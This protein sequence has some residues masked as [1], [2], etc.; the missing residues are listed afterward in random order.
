MSAKILVADDSVTIQTAVQLTL[1]RENVELI[2]A[3]SGEEAVR[4]AKEVTPDLMLIDTGLPDVSGYEVCR[5]LKADPAIR[6]VPIIMLTGAS[7]AGTASQ[8][9]AVAASDFIVKPFESQTLITK[10]RQHLDARPMSRSA[11]DQIGQ[12]MAAMEV[13]PQ[14]SPP[15]GPGL[16]F[17]EEERTLGSLTPPVLPPPLADQEEKEEVP[18]PL[19]EDAPVSRTPHPADPSGTIAEE[20]L[21]RAVTEAA[22]QAFARVAEELGRELVQRIE[23]IVRE[24]VP[25]LAESLILKEIERIKASI[26]DK[27]TE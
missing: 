22:E 9:Q 13:G 16:L 19:L 17:L 11:L 10:V 15:Q 8:I 2:P 7:E 14:G 3:R 6:D 25:T 18:T 21:E 12:E 5:I 26:A 27:T 24:A 23:R 4:R 20:R 1:S